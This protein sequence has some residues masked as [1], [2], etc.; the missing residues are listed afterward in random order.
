[1]RVSLDYLAGAFDGEGCIVIHKRKPKKTH[2]N[3]NYYA[4][5]CIG[6][7]SEWLLLQFQNRWGGSLSL[8]KQATGTSQPVYAWSL[9]S[10]K[11]IP[12]MEDMLSHCYLKRA[13][14]EIALKFQKGKKQRGKTPMTPYELSSSELAK[15][16][17]SNLNKGKVR[18]AKE[19]GSDKVAS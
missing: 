15:K 3:P 18:K 12:F 9:A 16:L 14:L 6:N 5:I 19:E 7:T 2:W 10:K 1:V 11:S 8:R 13:Q 17:I 4:E